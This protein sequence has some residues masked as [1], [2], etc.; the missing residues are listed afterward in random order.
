[1][2]LK[3]ISLLLLSAFLSCKNPFLPP[4]VPSNTNQEVTDDEDE[5]VQRNDLVSSVSFGTYKVGDR[6]DFSNTIQNITSNEISIDSRTES[7]LEYKIIREGEEY[8]TVSG[9]GSHNFSITLFENGTIKARHK[10]NTLTASISNVKATVDGKTY[11]VIAPLEFE[12]S[13]SLEQPTLNDAGTYWLDVF[14]KY[15]MSGEDYTTK[16]TSERFEVGR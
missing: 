10:N 2:K 14:V 7:C 3:P 1:M 8:F 12:Y 13:M 5:V 15:Q 6:F 11:S 16:F 4:I 9:G